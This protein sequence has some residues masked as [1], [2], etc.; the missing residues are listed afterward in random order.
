VGK[1]SSDKLIDRVL[2][3]NKSAGVSTYDTIRRFKSL[4]KVKKIGHAG[5]LDPPAMGLVLLLTGEATKL[6]NYLMDLPKTYVADIKLGERTDTQD[7]TGRVVESSDWSHVT[8]PQI[9]QVLPTL[10]GRRHQVP[11]MYSALKH[12]GTPLYVLARQGRQIEREPREVEMY[13][14]ELIEAELPLFRIE[15][16]CSRGLYLRVLAEEIG[17]A[18]GVPSHL[19]SLVRTKIGHF[20]I[21]STTPDVDLKSLV[22]LDRPGY[23]LSEALVHMPVINL[24]PG[25]ASGLCDGIAPKVSPGEIPTLPPVGSLVRLLHEDGRLGAIGEVAPAG[26]VQIRRVFKDSDQAGSGSPG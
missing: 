21:E 25:Q 13:K 22:D 19:G 10:L 1:I 23:S 4:F 7:A 9:E 26:F 15:V 3:V 11:P 5:T 14:V 8:I 24:T 18:L 16:T 12:K 2:P 6:S 17:A 20:D